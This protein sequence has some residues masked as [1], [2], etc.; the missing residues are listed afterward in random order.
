MFCGE[1]NNALL[2]AIAQLQKNFVLYIF[3][4]TIKSNK[5]ILFYKE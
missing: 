2:T 3:Q 5:K 4:K 1:P